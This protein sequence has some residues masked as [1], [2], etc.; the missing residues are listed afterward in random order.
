[1]RLF[2]YGVLQRDV[3]SPAILR[4]LHGLGES[5]PATTRGRLMAV[6]DPAGFYPVLL[7]GDGM[8]RGTICDAGSVDLAALDRFE[9]LEYRRTAVAVFPRAGGEVQAQAYLYQ[10][11]ARA[12]FL[13]VT[14]GDFARWLRETG[15]A[16][17]AG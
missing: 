4:L 10:F 11:P 6:P 2:F 7:P 17:L 3:A 15:N 5:E 16:P 12:D 13:P 8:V 9:G 1:M 14:H